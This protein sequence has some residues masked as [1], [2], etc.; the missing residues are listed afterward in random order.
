MRAYQDMVFTMAARLTGNAAQAEDIA[1]EV[2]LRAYENFAQLRSSAS[3][4][5]WLKTVATHLT[6][7]HITRYRRRWPLFTELFAGEP[8]EDALESAAAEIDELF[9][10]TDAE[11]RR[12]LIEQSLER[13]P[14]HQRVALVLYHFDEMPY[15]EIATRL[16]VSLAKV[17]TDILRARVA[18]AALLTRGGLEASPAATGAQS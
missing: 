1:Q 3:A 12:A 16:G 6:L 13:L 7:N 17:K 11:Q 5:G 4:G 9:A 18:M 8:A 2:F 15:R 10:H 14:A